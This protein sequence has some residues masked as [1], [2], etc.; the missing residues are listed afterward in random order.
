MRANRRRDTKPELDVRSALH[1]SG[2]RFRVDV[3]IA[4]PSGRTSPDILFPRHRVAVYIDGCFWHS[5]PS[6]GT[7]PRGNA[8]YWTSKLRRNRERDER[9]SKGLRAAGWRVIRRWE[10]E[11]PGLIAATIES[12]IRAADAKSPRRT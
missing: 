8:W 12:V 4:L 2:L 1:R 11:Q 7:K 6:H 3:P 5:C 9:A 10:H